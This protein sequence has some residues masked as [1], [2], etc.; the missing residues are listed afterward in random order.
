M[1][2]PQDGGLFLLKTTNWFRLYSLFPCAF[3]HFRER[4]L[5]YFPTDSQ[6]TASLS[7]RRLGLFLE[8]VADLLRE[9]VCRLVVEFF[10]VQEGQSASARGMVARVPWCGHE[11]EVDVGHDLCVALLCVRDSI[12]LGSQQR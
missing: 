5:Q 11:V 4:L 6:S 3:R 12:S 2:F 9:Q 10:A 8:L 1:A 7:R